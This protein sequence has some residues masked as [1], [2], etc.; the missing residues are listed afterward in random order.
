M[1]NKTIIFKN[2]YKKAFEEKYKEEMKKKLNNI[3]TLI[4]NKM[5]DNIEKLK[6]EYERRYKEKEENREN[7]FKEMSQI[8]MKS[9]LVKKEENID[10]S[11]CNTVHQGIK[12]EKCLKNPIVGYRYKCSICP[13]YNLCEQ[14]KENNSVNVQH[15]HDFIKLRKSGVNNKNIYKDNEY[16][17]QCEQNKLLSTY[18]YEG[19]DNGKMQL[20]LR[21]NGKKAWPLGSKLIYDNESMIDGNVIILKPQN[22][23]IL[24]VMK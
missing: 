22:P 20:I 17:Y 13:N 21:N 11:V 23:G 2:E 24:K 19:T 14:C 7:K 12:C 1:K 6:K 15:V 5:K 8:V 10:I 9:A 3:N 4:E 18:I 16:S